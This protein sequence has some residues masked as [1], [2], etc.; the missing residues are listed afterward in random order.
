MPIKWPMFIRM[1]WTLLLA[2]AVIGVALAMSVSAQQSLTPAQQC[3]NLR[4]E[5]TLADIAHQ[6]ARAR[7]GNIIRQ[8]SDLENETKRLKDENAKLKAE[9]AKL[10]E[11][12]DVAKPEGSTPHGEGKR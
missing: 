8:A 11:A 6:E 3:E 7:S 5:L 9:V 1:R 4:H 2:V 12:G 10:K